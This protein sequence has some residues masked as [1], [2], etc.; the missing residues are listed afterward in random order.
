MNDEYPNEDSLDVYLE[1]NFPLWNG[2]EQGCTDA[3]K[4]MI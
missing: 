4:A 3:F 2:I 1:F